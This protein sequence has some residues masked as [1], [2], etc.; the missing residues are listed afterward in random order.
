MTTSTAEALARLQ[1]NPRASTETRSQWLDAH[2]EDVLFLIQERGVNI[3]ADLLG[4]AHS[5]LSSWRTR[6]GLTT[7]P[8]QAQAA[9]QARELQELTSPETATADYWRGQADTWKEIALLLLDGRNA[10]PGAKPH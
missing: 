5:T 2:K 6:S 4:M 9:R 3:T 7:S 10:P 1:D 8:H